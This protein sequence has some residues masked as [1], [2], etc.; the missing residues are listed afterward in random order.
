M[1]VEHLVPHHS[2]PPARRRTVL[3][4]GASGVV[5]RA[6]LER[7]RD[8][9]VVALVHRT[10]VTG[11]GT[12]SVRGDVAEPMLGLD[13]RTHDRLA[14]TVD[15]VVHCAAVTD[16]NRTDGSLHATNV[17]GTE[18]VAAFAARAG[19]VLYHVSTAFVHTAVEGDRGR[20]ALG[21]A[22]SKAAAE[23]TLRASGVPHVVLRP[24]VV[25]GDSRTGEI[26]QF[27]GLHRVAAGIVTGIVPLIPFDASWP[28]DFVPA[29]LVADA[30][31]CVVER[32]IDRGEY[33]IT[34][35][36]R[37]LRLDEAVE[38]VVDTARDLGRTVDV[39]RF[40]AP[41][42]FDRL[43]GP[44]FL[45]ALPGTVRRTVVRMLDFFAAYLQSGETKP[46]SLT[47]LEAL[48]MRPLP[49][50]RESLRAGVRYWAAVTG[51]AGRETAQV[52]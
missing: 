41:E 8:V 10:P 13:R 51:H 20:A 52:A 24:S 30:I 50:Q 15:A 40:V 18:H 47:E 46:S 7:L 16:F 31:A 14:A 9:E 28:I 33:W 4:T 48:G 38:V 19:A 25:I 1:T 23:E 11:P 6:L 42:L 26:A 36:P 34:A 39:P 22:E 29:D 5:G 45:D 37:S 44:V 12:R 43:I 2:H 35:G 3:L 49:D 17:A 27:Q 21:Y 32:R